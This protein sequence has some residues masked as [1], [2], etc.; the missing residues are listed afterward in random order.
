M[1]ITSIEALIIKMPERRGDSHRLAPY[2][3]TEAD[4]QPLETVLARVTTD[5]GV[6]GWG[7]SQ[8]TST[9]EVARAIIH[10]ILKPA[11]ERKPFGGTGLEIET[12]WDAMYNRTRM[13]GQT[14][15][16]MLDAMAAVDI[17]LW[18]LG[19]RI[20]GASIASL[21]AGRGAKRKIETYV[22]R[23]AGETLE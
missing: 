7:E 4:C 2:A 13:S 20:H 3:G 18:D 9:P 21:I 11:L 5:A 19:G 15:G 17:A 14:G 6:A 8:A 10:S 22:D 12:L 1:F 23:L 16:F